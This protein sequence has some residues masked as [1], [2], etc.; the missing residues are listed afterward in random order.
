LVK[1]RRSLQFRPASS[2]KRSKVPIAANA[3]PTALDPGDML[4]V[5]RLPIDAVSPLLDTFHSRHPGL[6]VEIMSD[7]SPD[8]L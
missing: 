5:H 4:G 3:T 8:I 7:H 6:R 2:W 1:L